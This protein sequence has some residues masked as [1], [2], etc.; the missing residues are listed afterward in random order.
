MNNN[1]I[2]KKLL[3][4]SNRPLP[5]A[6]AHKLM[7]PEGRGVSDLN[8]IDI[9]ASKKAG[10]LALLFEQEDKTKLVLT[11]RKSYPGVHSNQVSLPGGKMER[12]DADYKHT[13][14]RE[15]NEE[16]GVKPENITIIG[17][18]SP[19]YIPP[20]NFLVYPYMG[21]LQGPIE[22]IPEEKEVEKIFTVDLEHLI[23]AS[24]MVQQKIQ[25]RGFNMVVPTFQLEGHTIWGATAM[26]L[27]ELRQILIL[28]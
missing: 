16:I 4:F 9:N 18:L 19:L 20:S 2:V 13:A 27:S 17:G 7:A 1:P 22:F 5:G 24:F 15:T 26:I 23:D 28:P 11:L 14:L 3:S 25:V 10:V 21:F 6:E 12:S 8:K